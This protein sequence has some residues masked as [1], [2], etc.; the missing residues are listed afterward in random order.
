MCENEQ[1]R[2]QQLVNEAYGWFWT[3]EEKLAMARGMDMPGCR[4]LEELNR[5]R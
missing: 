3:D 2:R 1:I 5:R 4:K